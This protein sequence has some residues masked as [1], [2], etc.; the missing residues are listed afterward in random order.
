MIIPDP[1]LWEMPTA[2]L[3]P[4]NSTTVSQ[5]GICS[6]LPCSSC[7]IDFDALSAVKPDG[8]EADIN[9]PGVPSSQTSLVGKSWGICHLLCSYCQGSSRGAGGNLQEQG[10]SGG[11]V[12]PMHHPCVFLLSLQPPLLKVYFFSIFFPIFHSVSIRHQPG[13]QRNKQRACFFH[14]TEEIVSQGLSPYHSQEN[15]DKALCSLA[16]GPVQAWGSGG[17]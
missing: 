9:E 16:E 14:C 11:W 15:F 1:Q 12:Y 7:K 13:N 6:I 5:L 4:V 2:L 3:T 10:Q 17:G 8:E